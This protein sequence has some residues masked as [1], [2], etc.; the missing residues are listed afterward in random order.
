MSKNS[1]P[2]V[3]DRWIESHRGSKNKVDQLRPYGWLVEKERTASGTIEDVAIIFLTN[4]ECPYRCL[5]CDLWKN[6]TDETVDPGSI[7]DQIDWALKQLP[8]VRH[9]KLYNSGSFFDERA[10]PVSDYR[11]IASLLNEFETVI[12]ESHPRVLGQRCLDFKN[13]LKPKLEVAIGL[14]TVNPEV[15]K[16]LNKKMTIDDFRNAVSFL[17]DNGI[18]SRAFILLRPPYLTENEGIEWAERSI[19]FA[20]NSGVGCCT[21]IPVRGGN[22]A[23]EEL[24]KEGYFHPPDI[25]SLEHVL[26]YGITL[27]AGRVFADVWDIELFTDCPDCTEKRKERII[28]MNLNQ[29]IPESV[30]CR[31]D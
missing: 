22:G 15:L 30:I 21:I 5:M 12:V 1:R 3:D 8:P 20:F 16:K 10:I 17:T 19:D 31:C 24:Q 28:S 6:T 13:M 18:S 2:G 14:E 26:E 23:M 7:P 4:R 29:Q 27:N 25:R 9:V 11:K